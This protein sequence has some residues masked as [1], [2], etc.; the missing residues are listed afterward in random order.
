MKRTT[1]Y[2]AIT[3]LSITALFAQKEENGVVY[4]GHPAIAI[5]NDFTG[6]FIAGDTS[7]MSSYLTADFKFYNGTSNIPDDKGYDRNAF[8][9]NQI[10]FFNE[11]DYFNV[12]PFPGAYPDAIEYKKDN[13]EKDVWVQTWD[14][15]QGVHKKTGVKI[16][17]AAHRL[18]VITADNKIKTII[19]YG[20]TRVLDEIAESYVN[21]TNGAIYDHHENINTVRKSVYAFE[22]GDLDKC[23]SYYSDDARFFDI[24]FDTDTPAKTK[25]EIKAIWQK[26]F[27]DKFEITSIEMIG[28]PDY[29]EYERS[30]GRVVLSWWKYHLKRKSDGKEITIYMHLSNDFD[31]NGKITGA[32]SY[33]SAALLAQ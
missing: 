4:I 3:F 27:L 28:Y 1:T 8:L 13:K 7:K 32:I 24:N 33:Y 17:A 10:R 23:L 21:R 6:A 20:N 11:L 2:I 29:L 25:S 14:L 16:D 9:K 19:N 5:V 22:K 12:T 26:E 31:A 30:E 18:Y 15:I